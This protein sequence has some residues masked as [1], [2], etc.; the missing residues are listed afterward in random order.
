MQRIEIDYH[1][2]LPVDRVYGYLSEHENL[3]P[4]FGAKI[5]RVRDGDTSRNGVGSVRQLR[6]GILPPFEE[7]VVEAVPNER[8]DYRITKG[9]PL[10]NH[11]G[12][13][14]F[15]A[16]GTGSTLNYVIEF[17]AVVPGLD[18]LIKPGLERT[19]RKGLGAIDSRG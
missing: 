1:F 10:R 15:A 8:I 6:I 12:S 2:S 17:G 16:V 11:H 18:R 4:V 19:I 9:S 13:M 5:A 7:T 14:R 3:G